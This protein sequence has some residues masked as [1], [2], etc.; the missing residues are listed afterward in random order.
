MNRTIIGRITTLR[1]IKSQIETYIRQATELGT[2]SPLAIPILV[3]IFVRTYRNEEKKMQAERTRALRE[4]KRQ[5]DIV[6]R[7]L[8]REIG[9]RSAAPGL[10]RRLAPRR[11]RRSA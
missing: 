8:V 3:Y 4:E 9:A 2:R 5:F 6:E 7:Q 10:M 1:G 11:L